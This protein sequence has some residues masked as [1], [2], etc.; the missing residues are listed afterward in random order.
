VV[1]MEGGSTKNTTTDKKTRL[2]SMSM[3]KG[4]YLSDI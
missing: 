3:S 1:V 2:E 4:W